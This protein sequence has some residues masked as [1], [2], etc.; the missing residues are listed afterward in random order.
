MPQLRA[1][2]AREDITPPL[3]SRLMGYPNPKR[4]AERVRDGLNVTTL[5]LEQDG[6]R[7]AIVTCDL[8]IPDDETVATLRRRVNERTGIAPADVTICFS[9]THSGPNTHTCWGWCDRD[10]AFLDNIF[11]PNALDTVARAAKSVQPVKLGIGTTQSDVGINRR[12]IMD[13]HNIGLGTLPW[14]PYDPEMTVLR[15]EGASGPVATLIHYGAHPTVLDGNTTAVSRDWPGVMVDRVEALTGGAP[16][17]FINGAVGDI[18]PR[19]NTMSATGDGEAALQEVGTRAAMDA[20]RA[21]RSLRDFRDDAELRTLT[22][23]IR[24]P[25][26]PLPPLDEA[27][28]ELAACEA[29]KDKPGAGIC[30][31]RHLQAVIEAHRSGSPATHKVYEQT[32]TQIGPVTIVP[33]P[34]EPFA[35]IILR[36]RHGSPFQYTLGASTSNGT[37]GY[38]C[39]RESL[40]RGG[41]EVWGARA[42]GAHILAENIDDVLVQENRTMLREMHAA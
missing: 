11:L 28:K 7:T 17:L 25:Y 38:L 20:M 29:D 24:M 19:S 5:V 26:R 15:F 31:Y 1:G 3:G 36:L 4:V 16:A 10:N 18:A 21:Y 12:A 2:V 22:R 37:N 41:Y 42:F 14:G 6:R 33:F 35:E 27:R 13:D 9:Q 40:H 39:T 8:C 23:P 30:N 32:I 34:G